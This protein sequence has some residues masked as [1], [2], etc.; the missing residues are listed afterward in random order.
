MKRIYGSALLVLLSPQLLAEESQQSTPASIV[1]NCSY[2]IPAET[3]IVDQNLV[4]TWS[5]K[6]TIQAF[7]FSPDTMDVQLEALKACFTE[8]GWLGFNSALDKSGNKK[9]IKTQKLSV[10]SLINGTVQLSELKENQWKLN[11]P[12]QVVYQNDKEKVTQLLNIDLTVGRKITGDL[13]IQQLV[14][15]SKPNTSAEAEKQSPTN[16]DKKGG[17]SIP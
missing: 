14:A 8:E 6:A 5:E 11:L 16:T 10:S 15:T 3:K 13:G 7:D 9:A 4:K 17:N 12:L 2:K 1:I